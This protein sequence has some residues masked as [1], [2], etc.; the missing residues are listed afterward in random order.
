VLQQ[1]AEDALATA[2]A[3]IQELR[4]LVNEQI[5]AL[6]RDDAKR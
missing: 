1:G 3:A 2:I 6:P 4:L 5:K